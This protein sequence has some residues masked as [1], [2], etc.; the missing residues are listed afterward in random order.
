MSFSLLQMNTD[1]QKLVFWL[2]EAIMQYA[3]NADKSKLK[4]SVKRTGHD[5]W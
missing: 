1:R 2:S 4:I 3:L 5:I